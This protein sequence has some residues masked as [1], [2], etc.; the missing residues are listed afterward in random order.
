MNG[1]PR[2]FL[3]DMLCNYD[4]QQNIHV[5]NLSSFFAVPGYVVGR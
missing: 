4:T 5:E 2:V 3:T 1:I